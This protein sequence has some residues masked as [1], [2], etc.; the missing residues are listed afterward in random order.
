MNDEY[1]KAYENFYVQFDNALDTHGN[2]KNCG[3][4]TC[5]QLINSADT[6]EPSVKH[7][8][9]KTGF[10]NTESIIALMVKLSV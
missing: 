1:V 10:M 4:A 5:I 7:G 2:V 8:D 3:R 9:L 6:L